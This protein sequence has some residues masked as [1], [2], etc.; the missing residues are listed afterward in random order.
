MS[1]I[2]TTAKNNGTVYMIAKYGTGTA[3]I[4]REKETSFA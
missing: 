4:E 3:K 1:R 2:P